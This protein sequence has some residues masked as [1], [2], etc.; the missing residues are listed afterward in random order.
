M[1]AG[2]GLEPFVGAALVV[3]TDSGLTRLVFAQIPNGRV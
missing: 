2:L 3:D 1:F